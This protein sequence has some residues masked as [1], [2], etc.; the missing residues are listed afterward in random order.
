MIIS[1][2]GAGA[3]GTTLALVLAAQGH[4]VRLWEFFPAY[5][6][7]LRQQRMNP[8]F[9]PGI[10]IPD[11]IYI[12]SDPAE[13]VREAE[14]LLFVTPS[15]RLRSVAQVMKSQVASPRLIMSASKGI[16]KN[17]LQRMSQVLLDTFGSAHSIAVLS[18]PSHAEEVSR[19]LPASL[20]AAALDPKVAEEVQQLFMT[21]RLRIYRTEDVVGVEL[22]GALKNVIAIAAGIVDGL[23]LGDNTK[24]AL[25]TRGLAEMSRLGEAFGA[26]RET[27]AGLSG[28]G[29]L[30][31]TCMSRHSRNRSLGEAIGKGETLSEVLARTEMVVEGVETTRSALALAQTVGMELPITEQ[32]E[33]ILFKQTEPRHAV[34]RLMQRA[35]KAETTARQLD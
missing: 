11:S 4:E 28:L 14:G 5:A 1:V 29:D 9:L 10:Q 20:V 34:A 24:A 25:M 33:Q 27:F 6:D 19:N 22:G 26:Q 30:M 3:W 8:K 16:E 13:A 17:S 31:V 21:D 18:G 7:V 35:A 32:V 15:Q 2:L 12:T 23:Q